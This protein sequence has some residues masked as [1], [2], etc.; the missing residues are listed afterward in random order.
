MET[1]YMLHA[2]AQSG[3]NTV[4]DIMKEKYESQGK[5]VLIIAEADYVKF[6]LEKYYGITEFKSPEGRSRIQ[7]FATDMCRSINPNIWSNVVTSLIEVAQCSFD[8]VIVPDWRF[9][10]EY[11]NMDFLYPKKVRTVLISRPDVNSVDNMTESQRNHQSETELDNFEN[12]DY[13]IINKTNHLDETIRQVEEMI[14][15]EERRL[16]QDD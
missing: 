13:N 15:K 12:Y 11:K 9:M 5:R 8:V 10:N 2:A 6:V 7:Q 14:E 16:S 4:A 3:K 1:I